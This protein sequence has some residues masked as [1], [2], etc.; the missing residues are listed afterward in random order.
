MAARDKYL[1][2]KLKGC[3]AIGINGGYQQV[4]RLT[5]QGL[6]WDYTKYGSNSK[7]NRFN[8][9]RRLLRCV[10]VYPE[11]AYSEGGLPFGTSAICWPT[12]LKQ[13]IWG[14]IKHLTQRL[15]QMYL[16]SYAHIQKQE[17]NFHK[18][19]NGDRPLTHLLITKT[20]KQFTSE[21]NI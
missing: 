6:M 11:F 16:E 20:M 17:L 10:S 4:T 7:R 13:S 2:G 19:T 12:I 15:A 21:N 14:G 5:G 18:V 1:L 3:S 9:E 8:E